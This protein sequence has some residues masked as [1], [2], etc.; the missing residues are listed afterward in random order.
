MKKIVFLLLSTFSLTELQAQKSIVKRDTCFSNAYYNANTFSKGLFNEE[1]TSQ[2]PESYLENIVVAWDLNGVIFR[3]EYSIAANIY[4]L[5][6]TDGHGWGYTFKTL[7]SFGKLWR[8]KTQLK[9]QDDPRG[10]VWDAMFTTLETSIEG[11]KVADLLRRFSQQA[12]L[13][14]YETVAI[15]QELSACGHRNVVL[16]NMGTGLVGLQVNLLK[17]L[18][19]KDSINKTNI[20][21][22]YKQMTQDQISSTEFTINFLTNTKHN[23]IASP[24]NNWLHKPMRNSYASCLEKNKL[25][26]N[27]RTLTIFVDDKKRNIPP[28][29]ADGLF[30]IAVLFTTPQELRAFLDAL[31][32]GKLV[33]N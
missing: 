23:V 24:E 11:K 28:A 10:Y 26:K 2:I 5:A 29:L 31:G 6:V 12:N 22:I 3:K 9:K 16:S 17:R 30:D 14:N 25:P 27:K 15:L 8:Y 21:K 20:N 7:A 32:N 19:E 13:L 4:Q 1:K 18:L 33:I